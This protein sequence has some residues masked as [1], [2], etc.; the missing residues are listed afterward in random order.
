[1]K[2]LQKLFLEKKWVMFFLLLTACSYSKIDSL[3]SEQSQSSQGAVSR[4][5]APIVESK[6]NPN[7]FENWENISSVNLNG[8]GIIDVP[9]LDVLGNNMNI[10]DMF[11]FDVK[12]EDSWEIL[13]HTLIDEKSY[14]PNY[15]LFYNKKAG[16][17]KGFYYNLNSENNQNFY[18]VLEASEPSYSIPANTLVQNY[19]KNK[20]ITTTNV[21]VH[22]SIGEV[23]HLNSG[24]NAF[25]FE[26]PY[27]YGENSNLKV[28]IYGYNEEKFDIKLNGDFTGVVNIPQ[29]AMDNGGILSSLGRFTKSI[30]SVLSA[31]SG[32]Y[33]FVG[34]AAVS[35]ILSS[36]ANKASSASKF[37]QS[38]SS[39][40]SKTKT[41]NLQGTINGTME[42][43]GSSTITKS[44]LVK[45]INNV[46]LTKDE[47]GLWTMKELVLYSSSS[48]IM[49]FPR[50]SGLSASVFHKLSCDANDDSGFL[51]SRKNDLNLNSYI[52]INP[53]M[54]NEVES[55]KVIEASVFAQEYFP[56]PYV[57]KNDESKDEILSTNYTYYP[58]NGVFVG[59]YL[60]RNMET[61]PN[62]LDEEK[63]YNYYRGH[64]SLL[65]FHVYLDN[66][67][68]N[69]NESNY[70]ITD[71]TASIDADMPVAINVVVEFTYKDGYSFISSRN[72]P[73]IIRR[74]KYFNTNSVKDELL[75]GGLLF[76]PG[77]AIFNWPMSLQDFLIQ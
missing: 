45:S 77:K 25:L 15:I 12:K 1:M 26:L 60:K 42:L 22:Q 52:V 43:T 4:A 8:G 7:L 54:L 55:F 16:I 31:C 14:E 28:S 33:G 44:G 35:T 68:Y 36:G 18:W 76:D 53:S 24:W 65:E 6:S 71:N 2:S 29:E 64:A 70:M 73:I 23:G 20:F 47:I 48:F 13:Y 27:G 61:E 17:L 10:P 57:F 72:F 62:Y 19:Q 21:V 39:L 38:S 11:R 9:W 37:F 41:V 50:K 40:F 66:F 34:N 63:L 67:A 32:I 56:I 49:K 3:E 5:L 75:D 51:Y 69:S 74:S 30:S 46:P 58:S 59:N